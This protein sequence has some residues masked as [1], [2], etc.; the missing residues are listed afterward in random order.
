M[1]K[2]TLYF[3]TLEKIEN[4]ILYDKNS[5]RRKIKNL[6]NT[7]ISII[8]KIILYLGCD[9]SQSLFIVAVQ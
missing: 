4:D 6:I 1:L 8:D 3:L 2:K 5:V 7:K 9:V